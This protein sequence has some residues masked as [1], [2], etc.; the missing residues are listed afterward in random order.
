MRRPVLVI[1]G[2]ALSL[3]LARRGRKLGSKEGAQIGF[4][5]AIF[6][7]AGRMR[8]VGTGTGGAGRGAGSGGGREPAGA[9][10]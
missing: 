3:A 4:E 10:G 6:S 9:G 1:T 7:L 2:A 5:S 8:G